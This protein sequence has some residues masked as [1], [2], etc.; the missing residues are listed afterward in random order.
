MKVTF[1]YKRRLTLAATLSNPGSEQSRSR[2]NT[3]ALSPSKLQIRLFFRGG[4]LARIPWVQRVLVK[5]GTVIRLSRNVS[6][7]L[8][9][10]EWAT[11]IWRGGRL[12]RQ[13]SFKGAL[14]AGQKSSRLLGWTQTDLRAHWV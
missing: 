1:I 6:D 3:T 13:A 11:F 9:T 7:E 2:I 5:Y 10:V 14:P 8:S 12:R 4:L